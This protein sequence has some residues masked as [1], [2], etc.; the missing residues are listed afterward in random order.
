MLQSAFT[1][2]LVVTLAVVGAYDVYAV[3][4]VGGNATVSYEIYSLG[5]RWPSLYL[6]IGILLGHIILPLHV[7]D[8]HPPFGKDA[9][10]Q[11]DPLSK[12]GS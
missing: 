11:P 5:K 2:Y 12:A 1:W 10:S 6:F 4:M 9:A 7:H 3:L 8:D